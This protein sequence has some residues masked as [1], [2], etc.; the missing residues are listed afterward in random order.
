[1]IGFDDDDREEAE[2]RWQEEKEIT[3]NEGT[4]ALGHDA[5][6]N[7]LVQSASSL[8]LGG[9][10]RN[11][12]YNMSFPQ[13]MEGSSMSFTGQ[14]SDV[15]VDCRLLGSPSR[16]IP[17]SRSSA[18]LKSILKRSLAGCGDAT[19]E[20]ML[21]TPVRSVTFS[22][23]TLPPAASPPHILTSPQHPR[24]EGIIMLETG[25]YVPARPES[26]P[27]HSYV[28]D[29]A[30]LD[31]NESTEIE[32]ALLS[33]SSI[34][35][36]NAAGRAASEARQTTTSQHPSEQPEP[37][38]RRSEVVG[39]ITMPLDMQS[40]RLGVSTLFD[41]SA[42]RQL[43]Q[44]MTGMTEDPSHLQM[45]Q[46]P[47]PL[48]LAENLKASSELARSGG[49]NTEA[50]PLKRSFAQMVNND[51]TV[52][53]GSKSTS[54]PLS[55]IQQRDVVAGQAAD[56]P[57]ITPSAHGQEVLVE[58]VHSRRTILRRDPAITLSNDAG[59]L[60]TTPTLSKRRK[61]LDEFGRI[62]ELEVMVIAREHDTS[63]ESQDGKS[64][65]FTPI[66]D[67]S[68]DVAQIMPVP[69]P[70]PMLH[71]SYPPDVSTAMVVTPS[72]S[73][74]SLTRSLNPDSP[75]SSL[76]QHLMQAQDD[77][78]SNRTNQKTLLLSLVANLRGELSSRDRAINALDKQRIA[79]EQRFSLAVKERDEEREILAH[80]L[81]E[82]MSEVEATKTRIK[83]E[84][85]RRDESLQGQLE[86]EKR[87][88]QDLQSQLQRAKVEAHIVERVKAL[89]EQLRSQMQQNEALQA[90]SAS[91]ERDHARLRQA[92][93]DAD[94]HRSELDRKVLSLQESIA[95]ERN[96]RG[97]LESQLADAEVQISRSTASRERQIQSL[98]DQYDQARADIQRMQSDLDDANHALLR[99]RDEHTQQSN[100]SKAMHADLLQE[101][102]YLQTTIHALR[103]QVQRA[104][105][106]LLAMKKDS[107]QMLQDR[108]ERITT[109][110]TEIFRRSADRRSASHSQCLACTEHEDR[111]AFLEAEV[112]RLRE[113]TSRMRTES[114]DREGAPRGILRQYSAC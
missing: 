55:P 2:K 78:L 63:C 107:L 49:F 77:L 40:S 66:A 79:A 50:P 45:S 68:R 24:P 102:D 26:P 106:A 74:S 103:D 1:M 44:D 41:T 80:R 57:R 109:L 67:K 27:R 25:P 54:P 32:Q 28:E 86:A 85:K 113:A 17:K 11:D 42:P 70:V 38:H 4:N 46:G 91:M 114:T 43:L 89:E 29:S 15:S 96:L 98:Q 64:A 31:T 61:S 58:S 13:A 72:S 12:I 20:V 105:A 108:E 30:L 81:E 93:D 34:S 82:A 9:G 75:F 84:I 37:V 7:G 23:S 22:P 95:E 48:L 47:R 39:S 90:Q 110:E 10:D 87:K 71:A 83:D 8:H 3:G 53:K 111:S 5:A 16:P 94:V 65:Y 21:G 62:Q 101:R 60:L 14:S 6:W 112:I 92:K 51:I 97:N 69:M 73:S 18:S 99:E 56:A 35:L 33:K 88:S 59:S 104:E 100:H 19:T 52:S 36:L 76:L